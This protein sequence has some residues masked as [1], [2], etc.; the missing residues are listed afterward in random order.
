MLSKLLLSVLLLTVSQFTTVD[1]IFSTSVRTPYCA[2]DTNRNKYILGFWLQD[3]VYDLGDR[4]LILRYTTYDASNPALLYPN[5]QTGNMSVYEESSNKIKVLAE[6]SIHSDRNGFPTTVLGVQEYQPQPVFSNSIIPSQTSYINQ[7]TIGKF[8]YCNNYPC[9]QKPVANS[10][11]DYS[12]VTQTQE[13]SQYFWI[14]E[15][16]T[17]R[18]PT[19]IYS[20]SFVYE[21]NNSRNPL[22]AMVD[23]VN[24]LSYFRFNGVDEFAVCY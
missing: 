16:M 13:N 6:Y 18:N 15:N 24:H 20:R 1:A 11:Y 19:A 21:I 22:V 17:Q 9:D 10:F 14:H 7:H 12:V 8:T 5:I 23:Y 2:L 3:V 4:K